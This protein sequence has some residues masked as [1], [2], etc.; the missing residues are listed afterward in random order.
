MI[1]FPKGGQLPLAQ[2]TGQQVNCGGVSYANFASSSGLPADTVVHFLIGPHRINLVG[3]FNQEQ[4]YLWSYQ[5]SAAVAGQNISSVHMDYTQ[6]SGGATEAGLVTTP[7][8]IDPATG[9][10]GRIALAKINNVPSLTQIY[11]L[12]FPLARRCRL[13]RRRGHW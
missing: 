1:N 13:C 8:G 9:L 2:F 7:A 5:A 11:E 6:A 3:S 12:D 4:N 10:A